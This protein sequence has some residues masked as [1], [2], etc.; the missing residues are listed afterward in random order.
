MK[1]NKLAL[2]FG[3]GMAVA[4]GSASANQGTGKVTFEGSIID[5]PCSIKNTD[6]SGSDA[7]KIGAISTVLLNAGK[8]ST[9]RSFKIELEDC[10]ISTLSSVSTTFTGI[11]SPIKAGSL[12][13]NGTAKN[14]AIVITDA[15]GNQIKLGDKSTPQ[16]LNSGVNTLEYYAYLQGDS[17]NAAVPGEFTAVATFALS[18]Q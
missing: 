14:A 16:N 18:Y 8:S 3:L 13:I 7:V 6:L 9:P 1:L 2:V 10:D 17:A 12:A 11:P 4:A 5:A 15:G